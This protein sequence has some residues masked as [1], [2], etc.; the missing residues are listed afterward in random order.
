MPPRL[1]APPRFLRARAPLPCERAARAPGRLGRAQGGCRA[2]AGRVQ[3]GCGA[4]AGRAR[5]GRG[6]QRAI[7]TLASSFGL[8]A[9]GSG[10]GWAGLTVPTARAL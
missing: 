8:R 5:D 4:G 7:Y 9:S 6:A 10:L 1:C 2:G 3:G